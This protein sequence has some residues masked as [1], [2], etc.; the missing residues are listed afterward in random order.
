[1]SIVKEPLGIRLLNGLSELVHHLQTERGY[2][3]LFLDSTA[4]VFSDEFRAHYLITDRAIK[5]LE[6]LIG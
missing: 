3:A 1:M 4:E 2:T 5:H 6:S